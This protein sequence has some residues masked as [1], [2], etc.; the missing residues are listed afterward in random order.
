MPVYFL[1]RDRKGVGLDVRD[2]RG[3]LGGVEGG[4]SRKTLFQ[5]KER[6]EEHQE[7]A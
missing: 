3:K 2:G 7:E 6:G 1:M 4:Q 5:Q